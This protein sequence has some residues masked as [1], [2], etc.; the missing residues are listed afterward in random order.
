MLLLITSCLIVSR[1]YEGRAFQ[2]WTVVFSSTD[3]VLLMMR[4]FNFILF[5]ANVFGGEKKTGSD[6]F[7]PAFVRAPLVIFIP[8]HHQLH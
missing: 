3:V 8:C 1:L 2:G 7:R 5:L 6:E 4:L